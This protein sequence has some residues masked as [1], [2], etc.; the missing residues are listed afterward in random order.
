MKN[1]FLLILLALIFSITYQSIAQETT[2]LP[3]AQDI[4]KKYSDSIGGKENYFKLTS[5]IYKGTI[6]IPA[7]N[8]TGT[9]EMLFKAPNMNLVSI[10]L[11]GFGNNLNG[12]DG[13]I[14]WAKDEIQG[15]RTKSGAELEQAKLTSDFYYPVIL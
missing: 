2:K 7:M 12:F 6:E 11:G 4:F 9:F 3:S 5:R 15:L 1:K 14:G 8:I 13:T 10:N